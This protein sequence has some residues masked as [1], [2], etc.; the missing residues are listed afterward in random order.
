MSSVLSLLQIAANVD[1]A[2][3]GVEGLED[4]LFRPLRK[5]VKKGVNDGRR[6]VVLLL[7]LLLL[8]RDDKVG[9]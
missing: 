8:M 5:L 9:V 3:T 2:R 4:L 6:D 7:V 1:D